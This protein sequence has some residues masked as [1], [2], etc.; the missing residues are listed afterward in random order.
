MSIRTA[1][2]KPCLVLLKLGQRRHLEDFRRGSLF[3]NPPAVHKTSVDPFRG[4]S[5]EC[6]D[7]LIQPADVGKLVISY[8]GLDPLNAAPG[9]LAGAVKIRTDRTSSCNLFCMVGLQEPVEA[10]IFSHA[11]SWPGDSCVIVTDT[12]AFFSRIDEAARKQG[13]R[14]EGRQVTYYSGAGFSGDAGRFAKEMSYSYQREYRIVVEL[15]AKTPPRF[16]VGDLTDITSEVHLR[17]HVDQLL[18]FCQ[19]TLEASGYVCD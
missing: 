10:P 13:Y 5:D 19:S 15:G 3:T 18:D 16:E 2:G 4:D 9:G 6:L 17:E 1:T 8:P 7:H 14:M 11:H 12:Q